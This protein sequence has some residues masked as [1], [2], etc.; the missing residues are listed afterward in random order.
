MDTVQDQVPLSKLV[1][2]HNWEDPESDRAALEI[3]PGNTVLAITSGGCNVLGALLADP[4]TIHSIDINSSQSYM[5]E[6]KIAAIKA[7]SYHEFA[8]FAG[9]TKHKDRLT[10]YH[11]RV[12]PYLNVEARNFWNQHLQIVGRR[13]Y[14]EWKI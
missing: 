12:K 11:Y 7:L 4:K 3:Q 6:L 10:I 9:L 8:A 2:T 13:L 14:N 5:L 1:F